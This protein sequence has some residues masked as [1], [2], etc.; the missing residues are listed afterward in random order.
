MYFLIA[1]TSTILYINIDGSTSD[2][3][4]HG[5]ATYVRVQIKGGAVCHV[6]NGSHCAT[7]MWAVGGGLSALYIFDNKVGVSTCFKFHGKLHG[8][9]HGRFSWAHAIKF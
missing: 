9:F 6:N 4:Q 1:K 3:S 2:N 5:H 7:T 8:K